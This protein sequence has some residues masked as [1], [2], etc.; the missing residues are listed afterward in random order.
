MRAR[1]AA[2]R[3]T[4]PASLAFALGSG[5]ALWVAYG[6]TAGLVRQQIDAVLRSE[7]ADLAAEAEALPRRDLP[8]WVDKE[9]SDLLR[10]FGLASTR[11]LAPGVDE[12]ALVV[13]GRDG[14]ALA[15]AGVSEPGPLLA[16]LRSAG[17]AHG[18]SPTTLAVPGMARRLRVVAWRPTGA[19]GV[20]LGV[21]PPGLRPLLARVALLLA[22]LWVVVVA[23]GASLGW[24]SVRRVLARV[25]VITRAAA[26]IDKPEDGRRLEDGGAFDEIAELA[27]TLNGMLDRIAAGARELR[28][29]SQDA[30]HDL[31]TP[32]TVIRGR[33]EVALARDDDDGWRSEVAGA[34]EGLDRLSSMLQ[35]ILDVAEAEGGALRLRREM[36]DLAA[37]AA[38]LVDLYAPAAQERGL[39]LVLR[40]PGAAPLR[41]DAQLL[42]RV[43][44]NLL[45]NALHHGGGATRV[46]VRIA[47]VADGEALLEVADDGPGFPAELGERAFER[48]ARG[49]GSPGFGLGLSLVRAV[50][51]AHGGEVTLAA[52]D[53]GG[54]AV[55]VRL[56]TGDRFLTESSSS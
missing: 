29:M 53:L 40:A 34:V 19:V 20:V 24:W 31:R 46:E 33:L 38:E 1:S 5:I 43:V 18:A 6:V 51:R 35:A 37:L 50:A 54:A 39:E 45:D 12:A 4:A 9:H 14:S 27:A 30:A 56:P 2:W 42:R 17:P 8:E 48:A 41:A 13:L 47:Q 7:A 22:A 25:E 21:T 44:A 28:R 36:L 11:A 26:A 10:F 55:T 32:L 3:L 49:P 52:S 15:W 23:I 16:A